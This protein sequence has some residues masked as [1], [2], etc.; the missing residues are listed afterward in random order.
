MIMA[1]Q[2]AMEWTPQK[3]RLHLGFATRATWARLLGVSAKTVER[4][5]EDGA[6]PSGLTAE[7]F[8]GLAAAVDAGV[9]PSLINK[10]LSLGLAGFLCSSL[11]KR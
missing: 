9:A 7:V 5:E 6:V 10:Q 2:S 4:W 11:E 3:L 1:R 8:R